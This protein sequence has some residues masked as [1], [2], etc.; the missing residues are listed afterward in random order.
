MRLS[1]F[2]GDPRRRILAL[3]ALAIAA[4]LVD[5]ALHVHVACM[6]TPSCL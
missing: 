4:I 5:L 3:T 6:S 2:L 1:E